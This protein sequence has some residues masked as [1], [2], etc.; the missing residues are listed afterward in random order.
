H[1]AAML[2]TFNECDMSAVMALRA[3]YKDSFEK[4]FGIGLGFM[5]FFVKACV[6][7]LQAYPLVNASIVEDEEGRPAIE[8]HDYCD[9]AV[10]VAS[11][12]GLVVPVIRNAEHLSFAQ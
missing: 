1:T 2:T 11:P 8:R 7:A 5:S 12:K 4:R 3:E 6:A 10:A 9:I